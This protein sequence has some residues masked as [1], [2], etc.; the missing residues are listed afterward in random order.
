M[1]GERGRGARGEGR[2]ATGD[3]KPCGKNDTL[4]RSES[5]RDARCRGGNTSTH[6]SHW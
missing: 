3:R 2:G 1:M 4:T 6:L 5:S